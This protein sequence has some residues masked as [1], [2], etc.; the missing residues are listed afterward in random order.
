VQQGVRQLGEIKM[1]VSSTVP[2][3]RYNP[4]AG[5]GA[6]QI[7]FAIPSNGGNSSAGEKYNFTEQS[8]RLAW[9]NTNG[10]FDPISSGE[11]PLWAVMD[12]ITACA[13]C[14]FFSPKDAAE[15]INALSASIQ[16]QLP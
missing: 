12:V 10:G 7:E 5:H 11:F 2:T 1:I 16:R 6:V 13:N 15:L 3:T 8:V 4:P 14:E 9:R